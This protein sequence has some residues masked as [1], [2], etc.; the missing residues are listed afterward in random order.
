MVIGNH[1]NVI[2]YVKLGPKALD[3]LQ[4]R[5]KVGILFVLTHVLLE[6]LLV[7]NRAS[8]TSPHISVETTTLI[9]TV[10]QQ[11]AGCL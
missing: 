1:D 2:S 11:M 10:L 5:L 4:G 9:L 7:V 3:F 6:G 8:D